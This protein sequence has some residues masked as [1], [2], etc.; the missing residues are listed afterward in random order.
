MKVNA[1]AGQNKL[2]R[3][4]L[5][6]PLKQKTADL[7][8]RTTIQIMERDQCAVLYI[9]FSN[10]VTKDSNGTKVFEEHTYS[11]TSEMLKGPRAR[12]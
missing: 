5:T 10:C 8:E 2:E 1:S 7:T 9:H 12:I 3:E 4:R 6:T 11:R